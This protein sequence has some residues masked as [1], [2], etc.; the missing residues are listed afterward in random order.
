MRNPNS[1]IFELFSVDTLATSTVPSCGITSLH[2]EAF[3]NSMEFDPLIVAWFALLSCA[4]GTEVLS[5]LWYI[6]IKY[7]ENDS[8]L[9]KAFTALF[10]DSDI[11]V[12]LHT[13]LLESRDG[14]DLC[15][16]NFFLIVDTFLKEL[17]KS[18]LF[19]SCGFSL[20]F[21]TNSVMGA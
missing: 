5:C 3:D 18:V 4:N 2:H 6:L 9:F 15:W 17:C 8:A 14:I 10:T 12:C 13:F 11:K 20:P 21:L 1:F 16:S 7:F 19:L